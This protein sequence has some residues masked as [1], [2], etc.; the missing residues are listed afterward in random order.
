LVNKNVVPGLC[1]ARRDAG[2]PGHLARGL[3]W[4]HVRTLPRPR[5]PTQGRSL[6]LLRELLLYLIIYRLSFFHCLPKLTCYL[7]FVLVTISY[8][9]LMVSMGEGRFWWC[10]RTPKRTLN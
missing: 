4:L 9:R 7:P 3:Q 6:S 8:Y 1:C 10:L 2:L 5:L